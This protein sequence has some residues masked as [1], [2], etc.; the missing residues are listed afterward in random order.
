MSGAPPGSPHIPEQLD[1]TTVRARVRSGVALMALRGGLLKVV[2][3]VGTFVLAQ[4][5]APRDF[6]IVAIGFS[7]IGLAT[8]LGDAGLGTSFIRRAERP[9]R[10][11]LG[12]LV[13]LQA[14]VAAAIAAIVTIVAL[15]VGSQTMAVGAVMAWSLPLL[16]LRSSGSIM[17]ERELNYR[18]QIA[19]EVAEVVVYNACAI[20]AVALGAGVWGVAGATYARVLASVG[21]MAFVSPVGIVLP[22]PRPRLLAGTLRFGAAFQAANL[23]TVAR[24]QVLNFGIAGIAGVSVLGLWTIS[25]RLLAIPYLMFES[26]WR[27]SFPGM[28]RLLDTGADAR[29]VIERSVGLSATATGFL[30]S[31][32][33]GTAPVAIPAILGHE[34]TGATEALPWACLGLMATPIS[35]AAG[36]YLY[37]K[38]DAGTVLRTT[39]YQAVV[40]LGVGLGLLPVLGL[41]AVGLGWLAAHVVDGIVITRGVRRFIDADVVRPLLGP[42]VAAS[43]SAGIAWPVAQD[44]A[45]TILNSVLLGMAVVVGYLAIHGVVARGQL[46]S[47]LRFLRRRSS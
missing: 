34:W 11:E 42:L 31:G 22:V 40:M 12:A 15:I 8:F 13:A 3:I 16:A 26:L 1:E 36:G 9:T 23:V 6:G 45:P 37:A 21:A 35:T 32:I 29:P 43:V 4:L 18:P 39:T 41:T 27:V 17:L 19:V 47:T 24:D 44:A 33:V 20:V 25:F 46:L 7:I 14:S 30:L 28:A 38:G 10:G 2:G 5:L